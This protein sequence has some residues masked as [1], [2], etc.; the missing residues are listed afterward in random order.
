MATQIELPS[1]RVT[2]TTTGDAAGGNLSVLPGAAISV[3]GV[4][5]Q[6]DGVDVPSPGGTVSLASAGNIALA[7][8]S[9]IDVSAGS[10]GQGGS[11]TI[12]A[13]ERDRELRR[14]AHGRGRGR[15]A[16][17][18]SASTRSNSAILARSIRSLNA[19]GFSGGRSAAAARSG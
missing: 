9:A 5:Q 10:G 2:L 3:A 11:L 18:L 14:H 17:P 12:S 7:A 19:G 6:Y 8:G 4:V 15:R 16:A 13:P 1:G